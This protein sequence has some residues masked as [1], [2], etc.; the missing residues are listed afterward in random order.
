MGLAPMEPYG[1]L[2]EYVGIPSAMVENL[3]QYPLTGVAQ[4][5]KVGNVLEFPVFYAC[6]YDD[7][8][9]LCKPKFGDQSKALIQDFAYL[10]VPNCSHKVLDCTA[11]QEFIDGIITNIQSANTS[12]KV[13]VV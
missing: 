9:D 8:S 4:T 7:R 5:V 12:N 11:A 13:I 6:G 2:A 1:E 10:R 3:T